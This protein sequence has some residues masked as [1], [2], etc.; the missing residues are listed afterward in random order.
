M[1]KRSLENTY[2]RSFRSH[3]LF[4][5]ALFLVV[6]VILGVW[7]GFAANK[8][9]KAESQYSA[10]YLTTGDVYFGKFSRFPMPHMTGAWHLDRGVDKNNNPQIGFSEVKNAFWGP[11]ETMYFSKGQIV[12]WTKLRNDSPIIKILTGEQQPPQQAVGSGAVTGTQAVPSATTT[13]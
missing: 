4:F 5:F 13:P 8:D 3:K 12:F 1:P 2:R 7:I 11:A 10:V 9:P 6:L